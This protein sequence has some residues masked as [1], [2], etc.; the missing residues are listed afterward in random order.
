MTYIMDKIKVDETNPLTAHLLLQCVL[1]IALNF[2]ELPSSRDLPSKIVLPLLG[3]SLSI[4][5]GVR[6]IVLQIFQ[7]LIFDK[8]A[9]KLIQKASSDPT[10]IKCDFTIATETDLLGNDTKR[11]AAPC[12]NMLYWIAMRLITSWLFMT[13]S[14]Y[15]ST[16]PAQENCNILFLWFSNLRY[17]LCGGIGDSIGD[18]IIIL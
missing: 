4:D 9:N 12:T 6:V 16:L 15:Y 7:S 2:R 14:V 11:C 17:I 13:P 5:P 1:Q 18:S 10:E 8:S 3:L